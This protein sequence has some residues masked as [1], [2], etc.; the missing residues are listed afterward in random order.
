MRISSFGLSTISGGSSEPPQIQTPTCGEGMTPKGGGS[1][2]CV[3]VSTCPAGQIYAPSIAR[4]RPNQG[5]VDVS[6]LFSP[7]SPVNQ[8][9]QPMLATSCTNPKARDIAGFCVTNNQLYLA[10]GVA[11]LV[12]GLGIY[13]GTR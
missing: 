10:G 1:L 5:C 4:S 11:A 3:P 2:E 9:A 13:F 12:V 8:T 6:S 7:P